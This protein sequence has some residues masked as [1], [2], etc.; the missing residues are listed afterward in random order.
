MARAYPRTP[1]LGLKSRGLLGMAGLRRV[2]VIKTSWAELLFIIII[3]I[4]VILFRLIRLRP[5]TLTNTL[6]NPH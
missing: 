1:G 2:L 4:E 6:T 5:N 3:I